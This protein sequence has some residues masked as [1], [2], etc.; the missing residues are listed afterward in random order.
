[1][2]LFKKV[3]IYIICILTLVGCS[4]DE[5]GKY[6]R[7]GQVIDIKY[8][9]LNDKLIN[10]E[11]FIFF[12]KRKDCPGCASFYPILSEFLDSN[13]D[14][15]IHVIDADKIQPV[16]QLTLSSYYVEALGGS[17]YED[18]ELSSTRLWTPSIC[19]VVS[20]EFVYAQIG[21]LNIESLENIYQDNYYSLDSYYGYNRKV[22]KKE[23]FNLFVSTNG[24]TEYD[25]AL[26]QYFV[27]N[28]EVSGYYLNSMKFDESENDRLLNRVNYY[29]GEGNEIET[30]PAYCL[31]Q[32]E[33]GK[34]VNFVEAK[35][36][37]TS[38]NSLYNK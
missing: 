27:N 15:V 1:M 18:N 19:K 25:Q 20:G 37:E 14:I 31:L 6:R 26:R 5:L 11:S 21:H 3:L 30:L 16:D 9:E 12:L 17:Y 28:S 10:D 4:K 13:K 32:Y 8:Q 24:D 34:L 35:Y 2:K 36:D 22:Q 33:E 7:K 38:L 23:T 29:L